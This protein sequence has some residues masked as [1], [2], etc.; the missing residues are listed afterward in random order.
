MIFTFGMNCASTLKKS[1]MFLKRYSSVAKNESEGEVKKFF[2]KK[3]KLIFPFLAHGVEV[4]IEK[5]FQNL[6]L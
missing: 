5:F 3:K 2:F 4:K 1:S 6:Q